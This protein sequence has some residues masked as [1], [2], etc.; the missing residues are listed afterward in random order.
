MLLSSSVQPEFDKIAVGAE[1]PSFCVSLGVTADGGVNHPYVP[2]VQ[3]P[4]TE[5]CEAVPDISELAIDDTYPV[6]SKDY[7]KASKTPIYEGANGIVLKGTDKNR[8]TTVVIKIIKRKPE[9]SQQSYMK[10]VLKEY[11]VIKKCTHTNVI[12]ILDLA[13]VPETNEFAIILPYFSKGDLLDYLCTLR[14]FK[15]DVSASIKDSIFK[16]II[17]GVKYLHAHEIVHR[18][19]KPEN[20]LIDTN[21]TIKI[22]D[23]GY[24]L[25]Q[26]QDNRPYLLENPHEIYCGTTSFKAPE[27]FQYEADI[28]AQRF[29]YEKFFANMSQMKTLDYWSLGIIYFNIFLMKTP[30]PSANVLD[31]KNGAYV[32]YKK[33][34]PSGPE[35]KKLINE[36]NDKSAAFKTNPAMLLFKSLHYDS[37]ELI[38]GLLNPEL[39]LRVTPEKLLES[40]WLSQ[41]YA[42]PKDLLL[43]MKK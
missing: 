15:I 2:A 9:L 27:L 24:T 18:D 6:V 29:D 7:V 8:T 20:C 26:S 43:L 17:K 19:L 21:G 35:L 30:W 13:I 4:G 28:L 36:L 22:S 32:K 34:Y 3:I 38:I 31:S 1:R 23:F 11:E 37:R 25:D 14:R 16:Q 33:L 12:S 5:R 41:V 39:N 10:L 40:N 42:N